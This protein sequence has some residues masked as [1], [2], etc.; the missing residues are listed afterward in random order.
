MFTVNTMSNENGEQEMTEHRKKA[1]PGRD[2][3][4]YKRELD[5]AVSDKYTRLAHY[6]GEIPERAVIVDVGSGTGQLTERMAREYRGATVYGVD[7]SHELLEMAEEK[8]LIHLIWDDAR[9]LTHIPD[10]SV[11]LI[12]SHTTMH[13]VFSFSQYGYAALRDMLEAMKRSL[14]PGKRFV[15]ADMLKPTYTGDVFM[16]IDVHDG[17]DNPEEAKVN[18][19]LDYSKLST[20]ALFLKF[21]EEFLGGRAFRYKIHTIDGQEYFELPAEFAHEFM[22]RKDYGANWRQEIKEKY[23]YWNLAEAKRAL[24]EAGFVNVNVEPNDNQWIREHRLRGRVAVFIRGKEGKLNEVEFPTHMVISSDKPGKSS[25][26]AG[27][28]I[29]QIDYDKLLATVEIDEKQQVIRVGKKTFRTGKYIGGGA[30]KL[31]YENLERSGTVIKIVKADDPDEHN[32]FKS[33]TQAIDRQ[34]ILDDYRVPQMRIVDFDRQGPPYRYLIQERLPES[35]E[36]ADILVREG[37]LEKRDIAQFAGIINRFELDRRWQ[38]DTS[39]FNWAR[40]TLPNGET[41]MVY[42]GSTVYAYD[43]NWTFVKMGFLEWSDGKYVPKK[44]LQTAD[45]PTR[46]EINTFLGSLDKNENPAVKYFLEYLSPAL[47]T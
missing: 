23:T 24:E 3:G 39:P 6:F 33:M 1:V 35:A 7:Y 38:L 9:K 2:Y 34:K 37:R 40:V 43:E 26:A 30:H 46:N 4:I 29:R 28:E 16:R 27:A 47:L 41:Q 21:H 45:K 13:E 42:T 20:R 22:L 8:P 18:G 44:A 12:Y 19:F 15:G 5:A 36:Y 25:Q 32:V 14:K 17:V 10:E 11:D 31:V